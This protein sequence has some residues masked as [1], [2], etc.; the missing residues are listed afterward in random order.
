ME[1]TLEFE[2]RIYLVNEKLVTTPGTEQSELEACVLFAVTH[3]HEAFL[4]FM[5]LKAASASF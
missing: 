4:A 3:T 1:V 5:A 2:A